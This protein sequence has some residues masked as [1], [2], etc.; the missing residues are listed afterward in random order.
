M[1]SQRV[2]L[3]RLRKIKA[4]ADRGIAGERENAQRIFAA[5]LAAPEL[6]IVVE[7]RPR[8]RGGNR[9]GANLRRMAAYGQTFRE[10]GIQHCRRA[11]RL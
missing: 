8:P 1:T 7:R 10:T 3:S 4:L 5:L 11:F 9:L 6:E 2:S